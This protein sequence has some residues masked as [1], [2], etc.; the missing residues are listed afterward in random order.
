MLKQTSDTLTIWYKELTH[1]KRPWCWERLKAGRE[2][3]DR[4]WDGWIASPMRWT[5]LWVGSGS[6]LWTGKPGMLQSMGSQRFRHGWPTELKLK[7]LCILKSLIVFTCT[8]LF[9]FDQIQYRFNNFSDCIQRPYF[10]LPDS[11]YAFFLY[12]CFRV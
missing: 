2:R 11:I 7:S 10:R 12:K 3:D 8:V 6:W 4:G 5:W 1:W 9:L